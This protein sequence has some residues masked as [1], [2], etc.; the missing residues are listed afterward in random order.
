MFVV[1]ESFECGSAARWVHI[2]CALYIPGVAFADVD[3]LSPVTLFEMP[4]TKWGA[5]VS[6]VT[7]CLGQTYV[8]P[9]YLHTITTQHFT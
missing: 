2:V 5:K 6:K 7:K 3:K 8:I 4:H 1:H 9:V